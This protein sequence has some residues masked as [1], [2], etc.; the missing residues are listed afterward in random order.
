[1]GICS[2][3]FSSPLPTLGG[4]GD[5]SAFAFS[6]FCGLGGAG[7]AAGVCAGAGDVTPPPCPLPVHGEGVVFTAGG[8]RE[9]GVGNGG[10]G[11][12]HPIFFPIPHPLRPWRS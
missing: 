10:W 2:P 12:V 4:L 6:I 1:M 8:S 7:D 3:N 9:W 5:R 11:Y